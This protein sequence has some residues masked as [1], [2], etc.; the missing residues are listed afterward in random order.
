MKR[1]GLDEMILIS[2]SIKV[3][4]GEK[5]TQWSETNLK[6]LQKSGDL[7]SSDNYRSIALSSIA[8]KLT[9]KML[10]NRML[11]FIEKHLRPNQ[12]GFRA[13]RSTTSHILALRRII[14]GVKKHNLKATLIFVDFRKAF[15]SIHRERMFELLLAYGIPRKIVQAI[16]LMHEGTKAKVI[17]PDGETEFFDILAGVL[18]GDTLAPFLFAIVL[19]YAMRR[20]LDGNEEQLGLVIEK[21]RS[22]RYPQVT[23]TDLDFADDIALVAENLL[24]AQKMLAKVEGEARCIGLYTNAKKTEV[25]QINYED[26]TPLKTLDGSSLKIV[27]NF[28][29]L[30]AWMMSS[31][32]DF[33]IRKALAWTAC[34]KLNKIW[35]SNISKKLKTRLFL[36]TVEAVLLYGSETWTVDAKLKKKI[37]G[38]YTR[39]LRMAY[40]ASWRQMMPN[41]QLYG[42]LPL[43][44]SKIQSRRMKLAGHCFRHS[45]EIASK[46]VLWEPNWG[47]LN[48]GRQRVTYCDVLKKDSGCDNIDEL[49]VA[50]RNRDDW[51][52]RSSLARVGTRP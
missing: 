40:N 10:L 27:T 48:R 42:D 8:A 31:E 45:E 46:L 20:A 34:H 36:A 19:D 28:K 26:D 5:P 17:S 22:R 9:N 6:P 50:M 13:G 41:T 51:K 24:Q 29:Y 37:D 25:M 43:L 12:N 14:E 1:S 33:E 44:S 2:F 49:R 23:I 15:D 21:R 7:S 52:T 11:P 38:C 47:R 35:K 4:N 39:L 18:Q 30:G 16:E 3:L 32:K